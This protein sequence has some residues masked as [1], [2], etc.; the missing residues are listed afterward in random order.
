MIT[1]LD[2]IDLKM[3]S[4]LQ[5]SGRMTNVELAKR[6]GISAPPCLRRLK[7][8]EDSGIIKG[9]RATINQKVLGFNVSLFA[10]VGLKENS[11]SHIQ[12]FEEAVTAL[13]Y[14]RECYRISG[15]N[16]FLLKIVAQ[17][18]DHFQS[19]VLKTLHQLPHVEHLQTTI[20]MGNIKSEPGVPI[21]LSDRVRKSAA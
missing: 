5:E 21:Q 2:D 3:L 18:F 6:I 14:V 17:D 20:V 13:S 7:H 1:K 4:I 9:Y 16:D 10:F 12:G 15:E 8:L 19:V 11:E